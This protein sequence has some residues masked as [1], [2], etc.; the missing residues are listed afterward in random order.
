MYNYE[1][2]IAEYATNNKITYDILSKEYRPYFLNEKESRWV[3]KIR[4]VNNGKQY[5]FH[6]GQSILNGDEEPSI[7]DILYCLTKHDPGTLDDFCS[8]GGYTFGDK[9]SEKIYNAVRREYKATQR[10]FD[11][12]QIREIIALLG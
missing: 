9:D 2:P 1:K 4:L 7:Y 6:Y 3:F 12:K 11:E 5:T 10:L 8:D